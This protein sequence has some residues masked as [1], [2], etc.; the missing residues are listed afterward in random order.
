MKKLP[1][2]VTFSGFL[3]LSGCSSENAPPAKGTPGFY[4]SAARETFAAGDYVKTVD[5]LRKLTGDK[6]YKDRALPW[7][8]VM[9]AGMSRGYA[10]LADGYEA[11]ARVRKADPASF[12]KNTSNYRTL[13]G[14]YSLQFAEAYGEFQKDP[15]ENVELAYRYPTGS[16]AQP[17]LVTKVSMGGYLQ[18]TEPETAEKRSVER[19]VLLETCRAAGAPNDAAKTQELFKPGSVQVSRNT[20]LRAM[21]NTLHDQAQLFG[22]RKLDQPDRLKFF[23]ERALEAVKKLP[24]S[25]ENKELISKINAT[26]KENKV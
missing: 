12:R 7:L 4:W 20:F 19:G 9:T 3:L 26:L 15:K 6:E 10:E 17:P 16:P 13:A 14:R 2:W 23:C 25:K 24:D 5:H 11:G 21:A 1:F 22:R 8:L 18:G